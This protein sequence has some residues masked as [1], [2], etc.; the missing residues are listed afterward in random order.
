[1]GIDKIV[2]LT[3]GMDIIVKDGK[4]IFDNIDYNLLYT[5]CTSNYKNYKVIPFDKLDDATLQLFGNYTVSG[6]K[7]KYMEIV[8]REVNYGN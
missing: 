4:V 3:V 6:L 2:G 7:D 5:Y 8:N 1:M